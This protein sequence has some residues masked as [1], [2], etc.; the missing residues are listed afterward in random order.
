MA[1]HT[2]KRFAVFSTAV[3]GKVI[4]KVLDVVILFYVTD[5]KI[6]EQRKIGA[7]MCIRDRLTVNELEDYKSRPVYD[8][9]LWICVYDNIN[10]TIAATGIDVY[11]RQ[12]SNC[13][14]ID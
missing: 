13:G 7:Q 14:R 2:N 1:I 8:E 3:L 10:H 6:N 11:K 4:S 5:R 9:D 12:S